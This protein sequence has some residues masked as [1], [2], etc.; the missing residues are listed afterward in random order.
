MVSKYPRMPVIIT[1]DITSTNVTLTQH[2]YNLVL[3]CLEN[4]FSEFNKEEYE[5]A[6]SIIN[7]LSQITQEEY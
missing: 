5:D 7:K 6:F 4:H 1:E 3:Y 2:E